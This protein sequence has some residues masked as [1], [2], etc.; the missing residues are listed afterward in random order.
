MQEYLLTSLS[1]V[2]FTIGTL[3]ERQSTAMLIQNKVDN[4][5]QKTTNIKGANHKEKSAA[6]FQ[7]CS[8]ELVIG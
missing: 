8:E 4:K 5:L 1:G 2:Y 6:F 7:T 3:R